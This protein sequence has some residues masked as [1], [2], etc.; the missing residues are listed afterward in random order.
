MQ[1]THSSIQIFA[2]G[3]SKSSGLLIFGH[4][5]MPCILGKNGIGARKLEGDGVTPAGIYKIL[6]GYYRK[7]RIGHL[8]S[9]IKLYPI[10]QNYGWC[11]DPNS[12]LYNRFV[13][14]P[15]KQSHEKLWRQDHLYDICLVLDHNQHPRKR[16]G[17]SAIFFHLIAKDNQ[18]TQGC[19]GVSQAQMRKILARC[20]T[21][22]QIEISL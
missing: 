21:D 20:A 17:G 6:F 22:C 9:N 2:S 18:P 12:S 15:V 4:K 8:S 14:L 1:I 10:K 5:T 11:D 19:I 13:L 3:K 16:N 7:D